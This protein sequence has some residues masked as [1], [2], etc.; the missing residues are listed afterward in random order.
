LLIVKVKKKKKKEKKKEKKKGPHNAHSVTYATDVTKELKKCLTAV[1]RGCS[2]L[3][4]IFFFFV[5]MTI[6]IT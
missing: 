3:K 4:G 1:N 2:G 6:C 5:T